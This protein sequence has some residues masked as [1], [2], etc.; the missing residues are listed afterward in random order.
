M[1][2]L[3]SE[4]SRGVYIDY[5]QHNS[6]GK[7]STLLTLTNSILAHHPNHLLAT[8]APCDVDLLG[9]AK[10]GHATAKIDIVKDPYLATRSY[11]ALPNRWSKGEGT[12]QD[13]VTFAK[14]DYAWK[15]SRFVI[16]VAECFS[17][18]KRPETQFF[19]L[20]HAKIDQTV[21]GKSLVVDELIKEV[22]KWT[23]ELH[24]QIWVYDGWWDK[25]HQLWEAVQ[26][27]RWDD[28]ILDPDTKQNLITDVEGFFDAQEAYKKF[29]IQWKRGIIIHGSPGNGKTVSIK[30]L[31]YSLS[32][33]AEPIPSLYVKSFTHPSNNPQSA[34]K[35]IF[36]K[37]RATAPCL[38]VLEDL[39]SLVTEKVRSY[40]L[41]E[42]DGLESNDG[43]LILGSTNHCT[44]PLD[45][46]LGHS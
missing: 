32:A 18:G 15:E 45:S 5:E 4:G 33:R 44:P 38:L 35:G 11:A 23:L 29:T 26:E 36:A 20:H 2:S 9:Y 22:S 31:M 3:A 1:G 34:I 13:H 46:M 40:F 30:A 7:I 42:V 24:E 43:I 37:A 41:N 6:V 25:S 17:T 27:S 39:D 28:V 10:A 8:V 12:L 14:Y 16:Y 21:E 19:V